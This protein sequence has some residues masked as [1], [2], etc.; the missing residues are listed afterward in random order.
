M[1]HQYSTIAVTAAL[2]ALIVASVE[3]SSAAAASQAAAALRINEVADKGSSNACDGEDWIELF[4]PPNLG[5]APLN[6]SG[7]TLYDDN[8]PNDADAFL[9]PSSTTI[10]PGEYIL[11]CNGGVDPTT[12]PQFGIGGDDQVFLLDP[13]GLLISTTGPLGGRGEFD[14]SYAY[15]ATSNSYIYTMSPT[16][17]DENS[18][19]PLPDPETLEEMRMRLQEQNEMGTAFFNMDRNGRPLLEG[20]FDDIVDLR[21]TMDPDLW[22]KMYDERSYEIYTQFQNA[23]VTTYND[24]SDIL[25]NLPDEGRLRPKGQSTLAY[26]TC[27]DRTIPYSIDFDRTNPYQTLFGVQRAYLRTHLGDWSF[28]R[29]WAQHQMLARFGLPYLRTRKV[30]FFVNNEFIGLYDLLEAPDQDYVFERSFP[31]FDP[32]NYALF[33]IKTLSLGCDMYDADTLKKANNRIDETKSPPYAFE[34]GEHR[35]KIPVLKDWTACTSTFFENLGKEFEDFALA[36]VRHDK[37]CGDVLVDQGLIDRDLGVKDLED[38]MKTFINKH[39]ASNDCIDSTCSNSDLV[40]D[41]NV[42]QFLKNFAVMAALLNSDSPLGNGNNYYLA[43]TGVEGMAWSIFQYDHNGILS[44]AS[45]EICNVEQCHEAMIKWSILRPTCKALDSNQLAGPLLTDESL[46]KKY[47]SYVEQFVNEV[48]TD[49]KFLKQITDHMVAIKEEALKNDWND[50]VFVYESLELSNGMDWYHDFQVAK[51]IP[52]LPALRARAAEIKKQFKAIEAGTFPRSLDEIN[53]NEVCVDWTSTEARQTNC[54]GNCQYKGCHGAEFDV[55]AFCS[56]DDGK[57]YHGVK[58]EQCNGMS[59]L[60]RYSGLTNF[61]GS[62][63][64]AFCWQDPTLGPLKIAECPT[65]VDDGDEDG[66]SSKGVSLGA[67]YLTIALGAFVVI[68]IELLSCAL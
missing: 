34:R 58:D 65:H 24:P 13:T 41:V 17:G 33:K 3:T 20:G 50:F 44:T 45:A 35:D 52:L 10:S 54:P 62:D 15:D 38:T 18:I 4:L 21:M 23:T 64:V 53:D 66:D 5:A 12:S 61:A 27:M 56:P 46:R 43:Y 60:E 16:P 1:R 63:K 32:D 37:D 31:D 49:D 26:G 8:G 22:D 7:Y 55:S 57:C 40:N 30:R 2:V 39:L 6:L 36:Y 25:L 14:V 67:H 29:E 28:A 59:N 9:F 47:L 68:A 51:Y 11:L 48:M 42:D 19:N